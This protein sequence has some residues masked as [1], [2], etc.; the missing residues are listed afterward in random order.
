MSQIDS[1]I[2]EQKKLLQ[3]KEKK[4]KKERKQKKKN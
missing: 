1:I 4:E 2:L 3:E